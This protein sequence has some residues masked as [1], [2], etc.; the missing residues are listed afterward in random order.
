MKRSYTNYFA[1]SGLALVLIWALMF[2]LSL[3]TGNVNVVSAQ[4]DLTGIQVGVFNEGSL[5]A[6]SDIALRNMF[7]WMGATVSWVDG[8]SVRSGILNGLDLIAFPG[9]S[10][11]SFYLALEDAGVNALLQFVASG[12]SYFGICG[13]ALLA[14]DLLEFCTGSWN[15]NIPGMTVTIALIEMTVHRNGAGPDLSDEPESYQTCY[16]GSSFFTPQV[17]ANVIPIMSYSQNDEMGMFVTR[18]GSGTVFCSSPHPEYEEGDPRD[19]TTRM[20]YLNDPDSEWGLLQKVTEWLIDESPDTNPAPFMG[21]E[22]IV[23]LAGAV[24][25]VVLIGAIYFYRRRQSTN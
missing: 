10:P 15:T 5:A 17:P 21:F 25:I 7:E 13:G 14:T 4:S 19:G 20:D 8:A 16:W 12:G 2:P 6:G 3:G 22:G 24:L 9:G 1:K 11:L 23:I 18:Y